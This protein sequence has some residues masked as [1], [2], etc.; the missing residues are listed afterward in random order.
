MGQPKHLVRLGKETWLERI[1]NAVSPVLSDI[2][3]LG[4]GSV[5][6]GL[7]SLPVLPDV[8]EKRGPIAGMLAAM[9]WRPDAAWVFVACDL[10]LI[11]TGAAEWLLKQRTPG[12]WAILPRLPGAREI[13][14]LFAL[15]EFRARGLLESCLAPSAL[16][17]K[18]GVITPQP[19]RALTDAWVNMNTPAET[20]HLEQ[21]AHGLA[22]QDG[23]PP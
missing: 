22:A 16:R 21:P 13:E 14:P 1:V 6:P 8:A 9:R 18:A 19:P 3:L 10:P 12:V 2:V 17:E 20:A 23:E 7:S 5:P 4:A 11:S 15:Y